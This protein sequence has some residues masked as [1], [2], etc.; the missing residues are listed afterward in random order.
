MW[1]IENHSKGN[2]Y[3]TEDLESIFIQWLVDQAT[4][5][6]ISFNPEILLLETSND[7]K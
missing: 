4:I 5:H 3:V 1:A 2:R 6:N 7:S